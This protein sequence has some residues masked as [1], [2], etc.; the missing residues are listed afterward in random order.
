MENRGVPHSRNEAGRIIPCLGAHREARSH[1]G[2]EAS[3]SPALRPEWGSLEQWTSSQDAGSLSGGHNPPALPTATHIPWEPVAM[4]TRSHVRE[5]PH[6]QRRGRSCSRAQKL[7]M[8]NI[9]IYR[10]PLKCVPP[11]PCWGAGSK[12]LPPCSPWQKAV[13]LL[14]KEGKSPF[15]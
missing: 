7:F 3:P 12:D 15:Q 6:E 5:H 1:L 4:A 8:R 10:R 13:H 11:Q 9:Q 2:F 14:S